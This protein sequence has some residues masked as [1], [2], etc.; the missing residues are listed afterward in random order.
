VPL[1]AVPS[2]P[3]VAPKLTA[4]TVLVS[5]ASGSVSLVSTLPLATTPPEP[6]ATPLLGRVANIGNRRRCRAARDRHGDVEGLAGAS[7]AKVGRRH[8]DARCLP[9]V[10]VPVKVR[11]V[12]LKLSQ[13]GSAEPSAGWCR[14]GQRVAAVDIGEGRG[15]QRKR[16]AVPTVA[17][18]VAV[19]AAKTG[20]SLAPWMVIGE[21]GRGGGTGS[22]AHRVAEHVAQRVGRLAQRL[23]SGIGSR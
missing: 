5:P 1:R 3:A 2:V 9:A 10:G 17:V 12:A 16:K 19:C 21:A 7:P 6:L 4:V 22:I 23:H 20:A 14:V 8:P 13:A 15:R 18:W 11:V